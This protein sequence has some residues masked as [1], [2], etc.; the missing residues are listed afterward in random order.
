[1]IQEG[2]WL[3][4]GVHVGNSESDHNSGR[5]PGLWPR[6]LAEADAGQMPVPLKPG[7]LDKRCSASWADTVSKLPP[8]SP[9]VS[10]PP[11]ISESLLF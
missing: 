11:P 3:H 6:V 2:L 5:S 10:L 8:A 7:D 4:K 9:G 1:M